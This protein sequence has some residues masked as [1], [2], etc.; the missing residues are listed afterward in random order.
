MA[1]S[2]ILAAAQAGQFHA[3][4]AQACGLSPAEAKAVINRCAPAIAAQLKDKAAAD[5]EAFDALLDLLEEGGDSS[6]LDD[7]DAMTGAEAIEDGKQI[8][9]DLY[10]SAA[11]AAKALK[12]TGDGE[13][14]LAAISATGVLAALSASNANTLMGAN[15]ATS[16]T[17]GGGGGFISII[18]GALLKGLLQGAGRQLAPKRRRRTRR[19]SYSSTRRRT[20]RKRT[21]RPGLDDIFRDILGSRR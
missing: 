3:N 17:G 5:P 12:L 2:D 15:T 7:V 10:G 6:D 14:R 11:A 19:Y 8:L 4:A 1:I 21:R 18:I 9:N 16:D 13:Q 20:T